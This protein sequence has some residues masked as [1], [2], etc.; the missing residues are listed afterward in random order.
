MQRMGNPPP[1]PTDDQG[2]RCLM[3]GYNLTG[4]DSARCPE[5]G[6]VLDWSAVR[7]AA[8][9]RLGPATPWDRPGGGWVRGF[10]TTAALA[11]FTPW[12]LADRFPARHDAK[13][14]WGYTFWCGLLGVGGV[15]VTE[16]AC[17]GSHPDVFGV[18]ALF[19]VAMALF[20]GMA[21]CESLTAVWLASLLR[22]ARVERPYHFWRGIAHYT[23]AWAVGSCVLASFFWLVVFE[24]PLAAGPPP[25]PAQTLR[26]WLF[27]LAFALNVA[28]WWVALSV[29]V[30]RRGDADS[31]VKLL[32]ALPLPLLYVGSLMVGHFLFVRAWFP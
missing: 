7:D 10:L 2:L 24:L 30:W 31:A 14:A 21:V 26:D 19:L 22:P 18:G 12:K 29:C 9:G 1:V 25:T 13:R 5:C 17:Q 16:T 23:G 20:A 28:W 32:A 11:A 6:A 4:I 3:C 27:G 8:A 15:V